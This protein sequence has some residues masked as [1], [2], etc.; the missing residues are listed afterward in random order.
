MSIIFTARTYWL[1]GILILT[2]LGFGADSPEQARSWA[3]LGLTLR[4]AISGKVVVCTSAKEEWVTILAR[5]DG[6]LQVKA[7]C[8]SGWVRET[9]VVTRGGK[10][11][12]TSASPAKPT[13]KRMASGEKSMKLEA[14]DLV[15]RADHPAALYELEAVAAPPRSKSIKGSINAPP[16]SG[17]RAGFSDDNRQFNYFLNFL[18][19]TPSQEKRALDISERIRLQLNDAKGN[20]VAG[21]RVRVMQ[22]NRVID[23]ALSYPD[24]I[25]Q[26]YPGQYKGAKLRVTVEG[27]DGFPLDSQTLRDRTLVVKSPAPIQGKVPVDI[28][29]I[30]DCTGS[31]SEEIERLRN[32]IEII[33]MNLV[34][35]GGVDLRFGLVLYRDRHDEYVVRSLPLTADLEAFRTAL[36]GVSADGGGDTPEA[37]ES[38]L[39]AS[40]NGMDWNTRGVRLAYVITD[41]P[42]HVYPDQPFTY[43]DAA[44]MARS[45]AIRI[46]TIGTGGLSPEGEIQLRQIAQFSQGRYIFLEHGE[47]GETDGKGPVASVS[48]H[49]GANYRTDKLETIILDFTRE[50]LA[51]F[52]PS[53]PKP[54]TD[55][56][57]Q[58]SAVKGEL[59]DS[60]FGALFRKALGQLRDY[61][62]M[63]L[64][65]SSVVGI[66]AVE[67]A[68]STLRKN[69]E[70][71]G[72]QLAL[73]AS[74]SHW[75]R[76]VERSKLAAILQEQGL[77]M[78]GVLD[79]T[80][81]TRVGGL[82]GAE[83]L[84]LS[85]LNIR[86][87]R[88]ELYLRLVRV[89]TGEVLA[90]TIARIDPG[91]LL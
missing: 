79:A 57:F 11:S 89:A 53:L 66:M 41:A 10:D 44:K 40:L 8:G 78:T 32:T 47:G 5:K 1:A 29:F 67:P 91:L 42:S 4:S 74:A 36:S 6:W 84:L 7:A 45:Q 16:S 34:Q 70:Y 55:E 15:G 3:N 28:V 38:A 14:I 25:A 23:S 69:A 86:D 9:E 27:G 13:E 60:T 59:R 50:D 31:M 65:D 83:C 73:V 63:R 19:K 33:H 88:P 51:R 21:V 2:S 20:P 75:F 90:I 56:W 72:E 30:L 43:A 35:T 18:E 37:L 61:S 80:T 68:D 48:H 49:T 76:Q 54:Q 58:A 24:G 39:D 17:L 77:G 62:S 46:H 12:P 87:G 64:A 85:K 52:L 71:L 22:E 26:L 81:S 82:L